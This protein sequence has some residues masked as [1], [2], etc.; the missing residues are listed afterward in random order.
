MNDLNP[1]VQAAIGLGVFI[2][3][4]LLGVALTYLAL[5][6]RKLNAK[7]SDIDSALVPFGQSG[8]GKLVNQ[9]VE[10][11]KTYFDQ[12]TDPAIIQI[13]TFLGSIVFFAKAAN[14]AGFKITPERVAAW[15]R[16]LFDTLDNLT[17]GEPESL[18][19]T[20]ANFNASVDREVSR[21]ARHEEEDFFPPQQEV[22][23]GGAV[24]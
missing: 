19:E 8:V 10:Q 5:V 13:A 3:L 2:V 17:D 24:R 4:A 1:V 9:A 20:M 6:A 18:E 15:G 16:A 12:P 7:L 22:N 23:P 14:A 11:G 21:A